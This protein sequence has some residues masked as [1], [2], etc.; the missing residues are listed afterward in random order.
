MLWHKGWLETRF[1]LLF[2]LG[3][4]ALILI[5]AYSSGGK[6][7]FSV[8][9]A[10]AIVPLLVATLSAMLAGAGIVTQPAIQATKGL[11]GSM[12]FTLS[13]PV[14]RFR[15][16]AVRAGIGWL[17]TVGGAAAFCCGMWTLFPV[18]RATTTAAEMLEYAVVLIACTSGLYLISVLLA[19]FLDDIWRVYGTVI[20]FGALWWLSSHAPLPAYLNVFRAMG[21]GSPLIT[22]TMPWAAMAFSVGLAVVLFLAALK[23]VRSREY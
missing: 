20:T 6:A 19:T 9:T 4:S 16:L 12:M 7:H 11:H 22:H 18:V 2:A 5:S 3:F 17:E 21:E 15:L 8:K 14:S 10:V 1:R 13:M 23:V